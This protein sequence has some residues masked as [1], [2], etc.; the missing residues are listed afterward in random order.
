MILV[1]TVMFVFASQTARRYMHQT[2]WL[3]HKLFIGLYVMMGMHGLLWL[4][5]KPNFWYH[6]CGPVLLYL[7]DKLISVTRRKI[8][9]KIVKAELLPSSKSSLPVN[10]L[11]FI[12]SKHIDLIQKLTFCSLYCAYWVVHRLCL[13]CH[14]I[15]GW[16]IG[17]VC[18]VII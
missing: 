2:F 6:F 13:R 11:I 3:S 4:T 9:L 15:I 10:Y 1:L 8:E 12:I 7:C 5:Q 17:Y 18:G 14:Y 16:C